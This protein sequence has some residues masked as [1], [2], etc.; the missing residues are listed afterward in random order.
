M[1]FLQ[2]GSE[3]YVSES[4][5]KMGPNANLMTELR[6]PFANFGTRD[7]SFDTPRTLM[8]TDSLATGL[9]GRE[10]RTSNTRLP[11][12]CYQAFTLERAVDQKEQTDWG[13]VTPVWIA[14]ALFCVLVQLVGFLALTNV[15]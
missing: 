12:W 10:G 9:A 11:D 13:F 6:G 1:T 2:L 8:T 5:E 14:I 3:F 7:S 4:R 15:F